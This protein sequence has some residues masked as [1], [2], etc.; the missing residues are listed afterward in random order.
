[1]TVWNPVW[2]FVLYQMC[3]E[4]LEE[5]NVLKE[6]WTRAECT[7]TSRGNHGLQII[8]W[9][10]FALSNLAHFLPSSKN[11]MSSWPIQDLSIPTHFFFSIAV[12]DT[13][14]RRKESA[15]RRKKSSVFIAMGMGMMTSFIGESRLYGDVQFQISHGHM[16]RD[17]IQVS[18]ITPYRISKDLRMRNCLYTA[19][20]R[21]TTLF[22][23][24]PGGC[25]PG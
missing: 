8:C 18:F 9:V 15:G 19:L 5:T 6:V 10:V 21:V 14:T 20:C 16:Q 7:L 22:P 1:M 25:G 24:P 4:C 23:L 2:V 13:E 17:M 3:A 12:F 11:K